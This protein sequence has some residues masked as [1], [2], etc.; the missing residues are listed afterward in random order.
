MERGKTKKC[1]VC[2]ET[3]IGRADKKYCSDECR[4]YFWNIKCRERRMAA[5]QNSTVKGI[6]RD[7]I[8]MAKGKCGT[9][10]KLIAL[11]TRFC[12][13]LSKFGT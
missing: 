7:L 8:E 3:V 9:G 1:P 5:G 2:G 6:E 4:I 12:K 13:I 10:I 11:V